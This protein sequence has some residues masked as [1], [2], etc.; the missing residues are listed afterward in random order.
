MSSHWYAFLT[1]NSVGQKDFVLFDVMLN[2]HR[3]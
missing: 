2:P 1:D 3:K